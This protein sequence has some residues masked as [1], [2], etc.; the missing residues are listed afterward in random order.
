MLNINEIDEGSSTIEQEKNGRKLERFIH[1]SIFFLL[2]LAGG[3]VEDDD[4][5]NRRI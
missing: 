4:E 3:H 5:R 2:I 1:C